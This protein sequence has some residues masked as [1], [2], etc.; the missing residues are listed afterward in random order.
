MYTKVKP[1]NEENYYQI[2]VLIYISVL[3]L[4]VTILQLF[5]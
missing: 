3:F 5:K 1:V 4:F 2:T